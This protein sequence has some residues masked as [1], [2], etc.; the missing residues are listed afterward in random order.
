VSFDAALAAIP[1][2]YVLAIGA[3]T[4]V[5]AWVL[6][7]RGWAGRQSGARRRRTTDPRYAAPEPGDD[8][9]GS[10]VGK[11]TA[12]VATAARWHRAELFA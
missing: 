11:L 5:G 3:L 6:L 2:P 7:A 1:L 4:A 10:S 9:P 12:P 8:P